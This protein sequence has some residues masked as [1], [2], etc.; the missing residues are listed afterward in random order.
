MHLQ[1]RGVLRRHR[2]VLPV[3]DVHHKGWQVGRFEGVLEGG[4]LV[5]DTAKRPTPPIPQSDRPPGTRWHPGMPSMLASLGLHRTN[6]PTE[7]L[8]RAGD[9][10]DVALVVVGLPIAELGR[11]VVRGADS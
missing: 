1:L 5:Q 3:E 7:N 6:R 8:R 4:H 9:A 2:F 11:E 10:P